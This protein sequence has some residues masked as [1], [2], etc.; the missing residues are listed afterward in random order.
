MIGVAGAAVG[1][2]AGMVMLTGLAGRLS[3]LII[4]LAGEEA[5]FLTLVLTMI[6]CL[7][8][9]MG[10]PT[11]VC[12]IVLVLVVVPTLVKIGILPIAAHMF[13]FFFG[14]MAFLTPPVCL[15]SYA[16]ATIAKADFWK[17]GIQGFLIAM[18]AFIL[19]YAFV[20]H[21][22]YPLLMMGG[23]WEI[24]A[25]SITAGI[26]VILIAFGLIGPT[27]RQIDIIQ[28]IFLA[29][30]KLIMPSMVLVPKSRV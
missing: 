15:A 7:I 14:I 29:V 17:T 16:A 8:L 19:P 30:L 10:L 12:Y 21:P 24:L 26:G 9:G 6:A 20:I 2:I 18:P 22:E 4:G 27:K 5:L 11:V 3:T 25:S 23:L 28:R 1:I 13:I